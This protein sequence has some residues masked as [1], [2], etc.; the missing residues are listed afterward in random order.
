LTGEPVKQNQLG[1][2]LFNTNKWGHGIRGMAVWHPRGMS[3]T[4]CVW[5]CLSRCGGKHLQGV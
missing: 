5:G 4:V 3:V 2:C 1:F